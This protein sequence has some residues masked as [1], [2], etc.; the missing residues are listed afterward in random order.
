MSSSGFCPHRPTLDMLFVIQRLH[1][2]ARKK[3]TAVF[4]CLVDLTKAYDSVGRELLW[5]V[6]RR[7]G[8]PPKMLAVIRNFHDG[9]RARV[10]MERGFLSDWFEVLQGLRQ[11][12]QPGSSAVQSVLRHDAL[13]LRR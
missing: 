9:M 2:L 6:L 5:G 10:R 12:M 13:R 3:G 11:R 4:A 8:V 1:E 7:F